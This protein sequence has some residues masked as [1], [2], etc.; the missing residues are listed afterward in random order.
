[1]SNVPPVFL[2]FILFFQIRKVFAFTW[3]SLILHSPE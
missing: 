1:L 3:A 2:F